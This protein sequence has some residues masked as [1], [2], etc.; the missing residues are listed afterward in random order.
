MNIQEYVNKQY[1]GKPDW[2]V[3][4]VDSY[5]HKNRINEIL[6]VKEY[7]AGKHK[8]KNRQIE[9]WQG[10]KYFPRIII[11]NY[12]KTILNFST[13]ILLTTTITGTKMR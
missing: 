9:E 6:N 5:Y 4:E 3:D 2:F 8:I 11:L 13:S 10:K 7:L 12:A 1:G